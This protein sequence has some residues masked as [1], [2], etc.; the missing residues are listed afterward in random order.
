[1]RKMHMSE[2]SPNENTYDYNLA[3]TRKTKA[4]GKRRQYSDGK[5]SSR[6]VMDHERYDIFS[7]LSLPQ[8]IVVLQNFCAVYLCIMS[9]RGGQ[10]L[11]RTYF[12]VPF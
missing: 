6:T 12:E 8:M 9:N 1:M 10:Q 2:Q 5:G 11:G 3:S 4:G 7:S